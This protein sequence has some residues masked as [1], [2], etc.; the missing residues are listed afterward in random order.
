MRTRAD[1]LLE[2]LTN[3][4][5]DLTI[6]VSIIREYE[7]KPHMHKPE[8]RVSR[9]CIWRLCLNSI[10]L[11]CCKFEELNRKYAKEMNQIIPE[12]N[13]LRGEYNE[14]IKN[15]KSIQSLRNDY[16][17]HV[18]SSRTK[19]ALTPDEVQSHIKAIVGS[20][21]AN[22]FLDWVCPERVETTDLDKSLVGVVLQLRDSL[23]SK[24]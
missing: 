21:S 2:I 23:G 4:M 6:A 1:E 22:D 12:Y 7:E 8:L 13:S 10:V 20:E 14:I 24:L 11:N 5:G 3:M 9:Q 16:V 15:N 18:N 17:A 19:N